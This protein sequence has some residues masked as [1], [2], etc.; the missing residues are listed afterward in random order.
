M[1]KDA[2]AIVFRLKRVNQRAPLK[3]DHACQRVNRP[4]G[5]YT[6]NWH[7]QT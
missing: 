1:I 6:A 3:R 7:W 5:E 4:V 2:A